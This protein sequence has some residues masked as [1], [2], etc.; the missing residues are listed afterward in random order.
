MAACHY[1]MGGIAADADGRTTL[2]GLFAVGEC[3]AAGVHGANRLASNSL[4]EAAAFGRRTGRAAALETG[5]GRALATVAAADL[6][7][8]A[9][10][11]LRTAMTTHAG[12]VRDAEGLTRLLGLIERLQAAHGPAAPLLAARLIARAGLDRRESRGGHFRAD[13]PKT[14]AEARHSRIRLQQPEVLAAE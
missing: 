2:P 11:E 7:D 10:V 6:P 8:G 14:A 13:H 12:V 1:H 5:G 9:L 3:A 4:L